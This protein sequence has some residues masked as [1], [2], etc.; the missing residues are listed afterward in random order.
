MMFYMLMPGDLILQPA[1]A[2]QYTFDAGS[3]YGSA[4]LTTLRI[5]EKLPSSF[6]LSKE[7]WLDR[8]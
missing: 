5:K 3:Y 1:I 8:C 6:S 7:D 4:R 2:G